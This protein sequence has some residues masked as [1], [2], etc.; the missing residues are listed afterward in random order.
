MKPRTWTSTRTFTNVFII[1]EELAT[2][3]ENLRL[4]ADKMN[5]VG[6]KYKDEFR[7]R[8]IKLKETND[9]GDVEI[10]EYQWKEIVGKM[11][12]NDSEE[13]SEIVELLEKESGKESTN[14]FKMNLK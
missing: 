4:M 3:N 12:I 8:G 13:V 14:E 2:A 7:E 9:S 5:E 11:V 6:E 10:M 1:G